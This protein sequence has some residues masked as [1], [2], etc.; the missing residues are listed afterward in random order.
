M[1]RA[2]FTFIVTR[3]GKMLF[4]VA[5]F[6]AHPPKTVIPMATAMHPVIPVKNFGCRVTMTESVG[7]FRLAMREPFS[8]KISTGEDDC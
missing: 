1:P 2:V 7:L 6:D 8:R 5:L 4:R 3:P